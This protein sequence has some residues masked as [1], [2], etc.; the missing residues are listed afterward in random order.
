MYSWLAPTIPPT[1]RRSRRP[2]R[3]SVVITQSFLGP[4]LQGAME[5][6]FV[7]LQVPGYGLGAPLA[8]RCRTASQFRAAGT[9]AHATGA[10]SALAGR[11][12]GP[13]PDRYRSATSFSSMG[14]GVCGKVCSLCPRC[15]NGP[16]RVDPQDPRIRLPLPFPYNLC[17]PVSCVEGW[18]GLGHDRR[19]EPSKR[20]IRARIARGSPV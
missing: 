1:D 4:P 12:F 20:G 14:R 19:Y 16:V 11:R 17:G 10:D 13:R 7:D 2:T 18:S 5:G 8:V 9:H 15:R 6:G 3:L